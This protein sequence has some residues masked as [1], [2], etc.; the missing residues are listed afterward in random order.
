MPQCGTVDLDPGSVGERS[1]LS[2][3]QGIMGQEE[4]EEKLQN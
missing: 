1:G 2:R 4:A 3:H